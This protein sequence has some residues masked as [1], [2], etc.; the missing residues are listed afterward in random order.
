MIPLAVELDFTDLLHVRWW[1]GEH[2]LTMVSDVQFK[3]RYFIR[4]PNALVQPQPALKA[5]HRFA[6]G[7]FA[8][9]GVVLRWNQP[10]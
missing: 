8:P 10:C 6:P 5:L 9:G 1:K 3:G 4:L 2:A 7:G